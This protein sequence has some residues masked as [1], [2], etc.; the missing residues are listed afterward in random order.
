MMFLDVV[1]NHFGPEGNHLGRHAP[2]YFTAART[3][4]GNAIDYERPEVRRFALEN[5]LHWLNEYRFDGCGSTPSM[6]S[7]SRDEPRF[8]PR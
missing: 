6:R 1:Y 5:A 4:W 8:S 3:P 2:Q 7:P